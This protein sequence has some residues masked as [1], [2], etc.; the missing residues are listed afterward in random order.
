M[1]DLLVAYRDLG[2]GELRPI[3]ILHVTGPTGAQGDIAGLVDSGAD[4]TVLPAGYAPLMGYTPADVSP[5]QGAGAGGS[6][7]MH[8]ATR[9]S[10]A[11]IAELP[12]LVFELNP[13]FVQGCQIALW[14]R[15]DLMRQFDVNIMERRKQFSLTRSLE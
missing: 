11:F 4:G 5:Q 9:S 8:Q 15:K 12:E 3:L 10:K 7:T 6:V 14:G 13:C 1:P 2:L